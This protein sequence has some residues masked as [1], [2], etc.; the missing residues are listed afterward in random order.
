MKKSGTG[1]R[2]RQSA[3]P[4]PRHLPLVDILVDAQAELQELVVASGLKVLAAMLE[5]DR[6]AVCG[7]R[8][9]HQPARRASRAGHAPSEVVLGGERDVPGG[10]VEG[11]SALHWSMPRGAARRPPGGAALRI[12]PHQLG[13]PA[14]DHTDP[15]SRAPRL[16]SALRVEQMLR[17]PT[18]SVILVAHAT[19]HQSA[20]LVWPKRE[21]IC[22]RTA[23]CRRPHAG[24]TSNGSAEVELPSAPF[25]DLADP[26]ARRRRPLE[27][28][29]SARGHDAAR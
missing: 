13:L 26:D 29:A 21:S 8:Y 23:G 1:I 11:L 27:L 4:A 22:Q 7:P 9:A 20:A 15:R 3:L 19:R 16:P 28:D 12:R 17:R 5:A 25:R 2:G 6:V 14:Y 10:R 18:A 24:R